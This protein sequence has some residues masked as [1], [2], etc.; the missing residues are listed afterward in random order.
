MKRF[1]L[2]LCFFSITLGAGFAQRTNPSAVRAQM[3]VSTEWL[4]MNLPDPNLRLIHVGQGRKNYDAGHIPGAQFL[5]YGDSIVTR[6]GV[7]NEL[8]PVDKL[9]KIF[10]QL[11]VGD[12][13]RVVLM[14][15]LQGLLAARVYWTLDYLGFGER[16]ALLD[17][18]LEKWKA[19]KRELSNVALEFKM[20][21]FTPRLNPKVLVSREVV[22]DVS[23]LTANT[24]ASTTVLLDARQPEAFAGA[25]KGKNLT[26]NGHIPGAGNVYWESTLTSKEIPTLKP[27]ADLQKMYLQAG[28]EPG[29][30]VVTYCW[31]GMM[32]SHGY[33]TLK[34]LGFDVAMYDGSFTEWEK[35]DGTTVL[36]GKDRK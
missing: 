14:C 10:S 7:I 30:K 15:D 31:I 35:S 8:P 28:V 23:W 4:A 12:D 1:S 29:K 3:L 20:S 21:R 13:S 33:F 22:R 11:G 34:Y 5:E 18:G 2:T 17:G 6:D 27:A 16:T 26:R 19:E 9:Q 36:E 32:A 24:E 25:L